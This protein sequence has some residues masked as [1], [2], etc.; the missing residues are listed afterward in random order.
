MSENLN[1]VSVLH[2][3]LEGALT[4]THF[5]CQVPLLSKVD[6]S[7]SALQRLNLGP[8]GSKLLI[9]VWDFFSSTHR[10]SCWYFFNLDQ[11]DADL[12]P[13]YPWYVNTSDAV[14][15]Q[16]CGAWVKGQLR[17]ISRPDSRSRGLIYDTQGNKKAKKKICNIKIITIQKT[18]YFKIIQCYTE[19]NLFS[20]NFL[21]LPLLLLGCILSNKHSR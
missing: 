18:K 8:F 16:L 12:Y 6:H 20:L 13:E 5:L 21:W 15:L 1:P 11:N 4:N 7:K 2:R 10:H 19:V 9:F 17:I 3:F 14:Y